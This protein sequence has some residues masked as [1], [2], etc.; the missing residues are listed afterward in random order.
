M[1]AVLLA[2]LSTVARTFL[3]AIAALLSVAI[4]KLLTTYI[5]P[6][7]SELRQLPG[8]PGGSWITGHVADLNRSQTDRAE[9]ILEWSKQYGHVF[10][11]KSLLNVSRRFI[12]PVYFSSHV[13]NS[14]TAW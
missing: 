12:C 11:Y 4:L 7:F 2:L 14:R 13:C 8:P 1:P 5:R 3:W 10:A 9:C 6:Y